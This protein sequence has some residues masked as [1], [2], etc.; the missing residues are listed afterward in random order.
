MAKQDLEVQRRFLPK[1]CA[2]GLL[3]SRDPSQR[4]PTWHGSL[5]FELLYW[6]FEVLQCCSQ[7]ALF[8]RRVG[9]AGLE[10]VVMVCPV[11]KLEMPAGGALTEKRASELAIMARDSRL[12]VLEMSRGTP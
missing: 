8:L 12:L 1:S 6:L 2:A 9:E 11:T 5:L 4:W 3:W 10:R 7:I